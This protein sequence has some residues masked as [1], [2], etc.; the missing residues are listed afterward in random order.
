MSLDSS[1]E[2][3]R[4]YQLVTVRLTDGRS[5]SGIVVKD[6]PTAITMRTLAGNQVILRRDLAKDEPDRPAIEYSKFSL[7]PP[8]QLQVLT[9]EEARDLLGYLMGTRQAPITASPENVGS[10]FNGRDLTGWDADPAVWRVE[11]GELVG[12]TATGLKKNDFARSELLLGDFRLVFAVKLTPDSANSGV[13]FRSQSLQDGE[14]K[15]YQ[16]DIGKGWWGLLYEESGR[17]VLAKAAANPVQPEE[18]NTYE[19]LAVGARIQLAINGVRTVDLEDGG[20]ERRGVIAPQVHSG[21][22][23]E[24]RFRGFRLEIDPKPV[25]ST[26]RGGGGRGGQ[27]AGRWGVGEVS[28]GRQKT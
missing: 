27:K 21:G 24:V 15:G 2:V 23:T 12:K 4:E 20:G 28:E 22:P 10:F 18:W 9:Q 16:A 14:M 8:G 13:Q 3:G 11:N 17:G 7:M 1:A 19:I 26:G 25:L 6:T 5:I